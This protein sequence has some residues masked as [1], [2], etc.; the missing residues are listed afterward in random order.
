MYFIVIAGPNGAGK[1]TTSKELLKPHKITA[2]DWD[3]RFQKRWSKFDFDPILADGIRESTNIEFE[4]HISS[5]FN[6]QQS[7]AYETNFHSHF[8]LDLAKKAKEFGYRTVLHFLSL[9]TPEL[10]VARVDERVNNGGH[11]VSKNTI[12]ER[13]RKGLEMLD[14][15]A[16]HYYDDIAIYDSAEVFKAQTVIENKKVTYTTEQPNQIIF[17]HLPKLR[18]LLN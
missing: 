4:E 11:S 16:I 13:F 6:S 12:Y 10:A 7:V 15:K 14:N 9:E 5:A 1:S 3:E 18:S 2:F 17:R 8:N